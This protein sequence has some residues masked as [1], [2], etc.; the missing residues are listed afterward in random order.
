MQ[1]IGLER[2]LE[3]N[4]KRNIWILI[5]IL[6]LI[7]GGFVLTA[8]GKNDD[9]K[10]SNL[11]NDFYSIDETN[12]TIVTSKQT[13]KLNYENYKD[14]NVKYML[15]IINNP[16]YPYQYLKEYQT[17]LDDVLSFTYS[18]IDVCSS[19]DLEVPSELKNKTKQDL[20]ALQEAFIDLDY[21]FESFASLVHFNL[22][23]T[24][25]TDPI[26]LSSYKKVLGDFENVIVEAVDFSDDI[27]KIYYQHVLNNPNPNFFVESEDFSAGKVESYLT[28]RI[29]FQTNNLARVFVEKYFDG[30]DIDKQLSSKN[31][32]NN[33]FESEEYNLYTSNVE[34]INKDLKNKA[35]AIDT[36]A[37]LNK[38]IEMYNAQEILNNDDKK[39]KTA[40]QEIEY[41]TILASK[42]K[43][44]AQKIYLKIVDDYDYLVQQYNAV[45]VDIIDILLGE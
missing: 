17:L 9:Y 31:F 36:K 1:H 21:Q 43:T 35:E 30:A 34:K 39:F 27:A 5:L 15:D 6:L 19:N 29:K 14:N 10:L 3:F 42:D 2:F 38:S 32:A 40:C 16:A 7:P 41:Q 11:K 25:K 37:L 13:L 18:Y 22:S 26:L 28:S 8:C 23:N 20:I 44:E 45:L 24:D 33:L 12:A 4:M